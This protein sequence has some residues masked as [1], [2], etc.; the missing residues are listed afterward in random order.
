MK[1]VASICDNYMQQLGPDWRE[2]SYVTDLYKVLAISREI[3]NKHLRA[4]AQGAFHG[5]SSAPLPPH[6]IQHGVTTLP[7]TL[8]IQ[9]PI[10][11]SPSTLTSGTPMAVSQSHTS[12]NIYST[13]NTSISLSSPTPSTSTTGSQA[14]VCRVCLTSFTGDYQKSNYERHM[15]TT[16]KHGESSGL[17]CQVADCGKI[18]SRSDNMSKHMRIKHHIVTP[19]RSQIPKRR[20]RSMD[21]EG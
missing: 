6:N 1:L 10:E 8:T 17:P 16:K 2:R 14:K 18:L 21:A 15:R 20:K 7:G 3:D 4:I 5:P 11:T 13:P 12:E 9:S 19:S